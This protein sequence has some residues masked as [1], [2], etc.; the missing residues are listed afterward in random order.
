[1]AALDWQRSDAAESCVDAAGLASGVEAR[2]HR[3][4]FG[5]RAGADVVVQV[6][7]TRREDGPW[8]AQIELRSVD[9]QLVGT[10]EL[11]TA[12]EH[13]SALD[14]SLNLA[15]ALM[16]D[17]SVD[18]LPVPAPPV[19]QVVRPRTPIEL[20]RRTH[21][22]REPWR[23]RTA[24][25]GTVAIGLLPGPAPGVRGS[26]GVEPPTFWL[27]ELDVTWWPA[28][29][30]SSGDEGA[31]ATFLTLGA[32]LCPVGV[33]TRTTHV[34]LCFGQEVGRLSVGGFGFDRNDDRTR[35]TYDIGLRARASQR[36]VGALA[37]FVGVQGLVPLSRDRFV[38]DEANGAR[39]QV[40]RRPFLAGAAEV[41]IGLD[42]DP[43]K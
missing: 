1:M 13:C 12:A 9:G 4:V 36:V 28:Q 19:R 14:E 31:R 22:P 37:L 29:E 25:L 5:P 39:R 24:A 7:L 42:F 41:G 33:G 40:F 38:A 15:I 2:L 30:D 32:Y 20:P 10:R 35:L 26:V 27:T 21:A 17:L 3:T 23:L 18:E 8:L 43:I 34:S 16:V 11:V 6:R